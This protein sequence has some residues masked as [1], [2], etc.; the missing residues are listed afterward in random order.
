ML[1][2]V[3]AS[4][5]TTHAADSTKSSGAGAIIGQFDREGDT[6]RLLDGGKAISKDGMKGRYKNLKGARK[7]LM[8]DTADGSYSFLILADT[9][10][11]EI[12]AGSMGVIT[13]F[14]YDAD[15]HMVIF[16]ELDGGPITYDDLEFLEIED[17]IVPVFEFDSLGPMNWEYMQYRKASDGS[18]TPLLGIMNFCNYAESFHRGPTGKTSGE[19]MKIIEKAGYK[20]VDTFPSSATLFD[21]MEDEYFEVPAITVK[22]SNGNSTILCKC[23]TVEYEGKELDYNYIPFNITI[24]EDGDMTST[25]KNF[26]DDAKEHGFR[27]DEN[28]EGNLYIPASHIYVACFR[29]NNGNDAF[30]DIEFNDYN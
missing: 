26:I 23:R 2:A 3:V 18:T 29:V 30:I 11:Y 17:T 8:G 10:V 5:M 28:S 21:D 7:V 22:Y 9:A 25:I 12:S 4:V 27:R 20:K 24:R 13:D 16:T 15:R 19:I 1:T 6:I 14:D